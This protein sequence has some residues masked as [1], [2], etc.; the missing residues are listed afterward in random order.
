MPELGPPLARLAP[1]DE[2]PPPEPAKPP[3]AGYGQAGAIGRRVEL[4]LYQEQLEVQHAAVL[5]GPPGVGKTTLAAMLCQAD[6]SARI[7]WHSF[8]KAQGVYDLIWVMAAW[9]AWYGSE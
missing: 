7:F 4:L 2:P 3:V 6:P 8:H 1:S 5:V 9:L